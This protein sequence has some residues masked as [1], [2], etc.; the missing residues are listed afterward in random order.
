MLLTLVTWTQKPDGLPAFREIRERGKS[1]SP[2]IPPTNIQRHPHHSL[3]G[4]QRVL[5]SSL[6]QQAGVHA[7]QN[8]DGDLKVSASAWSRCFLSAAVW[9]GPWVVFQVS[10]WP[11]WTEG[12]FPGA[13]TF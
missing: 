1:G 10:E 8:S 6:L 4:A 13:Q 9:C 2:L 5:T 11:W 12:S 7:D 3:W